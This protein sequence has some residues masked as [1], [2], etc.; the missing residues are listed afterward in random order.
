MLTCEELCNAAP[1]K[2][3]GCT[4]MGTI[5]LGLKIGVGIAIGLLVVYYIWRELRALPET[6]RTLRFSRAGFD[7]AEGPQGWLSRDPSNDDWILWDERNKRMLRATDPD[8]N[9]MPSG[10]TQEQCIALGRKYREQIGF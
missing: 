6:F 1:A 3:E 9:W 4:P 10:E 7:W 5:W 8:G 2:R